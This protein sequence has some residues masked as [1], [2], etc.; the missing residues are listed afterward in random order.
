MNYRVGAF[1]FG[2]WPGIGGR[3]W[4]TSGNIGLQDQLMALAWVR[5][6]I[7]AFGGDPENITVAGHS[8]GAFSIGCLQG[9][10]SARGLFA[11]AIMSSGHT[12]RIIPVETA[13]AVAREL[14]G[15][16]GIRSMTELQTVDPER[17]LEAQFAVV[18]SDIG[19]RN[20]PGRRVWGFVLDGHVLHQHPQA[21]LAA[22]QLT[23][24]PLNL[25]IRESFTSACREFI[26]DGRVGWARYTAADVDNIRQF[27]GDAD[28]VTEPPSAITEVW[29]M[30]TSLSS[31]S[32]AQISSTETT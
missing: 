21:V 11:K 6:N 28:V 27:G 13:T 23:D 17:I 25:A 16:L 32:S 29:P 15:E 31:R 4:E 22:G 14:W 19:A 26:R 30:N 10:P 20:L 5:R 12:G 2:Y 9:A 24:I 1:R 8:A 7:A 3:G 18:D